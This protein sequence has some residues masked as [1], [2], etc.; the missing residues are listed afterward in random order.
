MNSRTSANTGTTTAGPTG[1][2]PDTDTTGSHVTD[3]DA[4]P[5][6]LT[7]LAFHGP[8]S[9]ARADRVV[10]R[11]AEPLVRAGGGSVL[12][13]GC[14]WGEMLLRVLQAAPG[15]TGVGVDLN[16]EDL[17]RGRASARARGLGARVEF[18]A[19][20]A[21]DTARGPADVVL[22][23]GSA[24]ALCPADTPPPYTAD[25]LRALRGLVA[26]G[27]R[28]VLGESF[29]QRTPTA[30]DLAALW[31]DARADEHLDLGG[32]AEAAVAA[33]FRPLWVETAG[34]EEWEEFES[35]YLADTEEWLAAHPGHPRAAEL[36]ERADRHRATFLR[37]YRR[38]LGFAYLT[39]V[40]V[41]A[42]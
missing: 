40:P 20:S 9:Q 24:H 18:A 28:V 2:A 1:T 7:R 19:E 11:A 27:G 42:H 32:L 6:R 25:A 41:A 3:P 4:A 10:R 16:D 17:A 39:L 14:G 31:P 36:R 12:D 22:C 13:L 5:P 33:G 8:L 30:A 29:W 35:A 26:P 34:E 15:A 38:L 23:L 37:G 21:T